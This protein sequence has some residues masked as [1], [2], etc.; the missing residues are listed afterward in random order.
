MNIG[1]PEWRRWVAHA[2][3]VNPPQEAITP[4]EEALA[5]RFARFVVNR[6][7]TA[8]AVTVLESSR[9]YTFLGSQLLTFMSPFIHILFRGQD[10]DRFV[11]FIEKRRSVDHILDALARVQDER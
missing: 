4:E 11:R 2:F 9:P 1:W 3:A 5:E 6:D 7:L 8:P 10:Y